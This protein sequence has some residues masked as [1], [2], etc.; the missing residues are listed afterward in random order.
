MLVNLSINGKCKTFSV[1]SLIAQAYIPNPDNLP[2]INH[3]DGNKE[4][5][6]VTNLKWCSASYN[7]T[8]DLQK[9][10]TMKYIQNLERSP[11][12]KEDSDVSF[13]LSDGTFYKGTVARGDGFYINLYDKYNDSIFKELSLNKDTFMQSAVGYTPSGSWPEARSLEDLEKVL[14]AL[15]KVHRPE[16][17]EKTEEKPKPPSEWD[18]LFD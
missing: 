12:L 9:K 15:L 10:K 11:K 5:N 13:T 16:E 4:N 3:I 17:V 1:H 18:W 14:D 8:R 7:C 6:C 2:E